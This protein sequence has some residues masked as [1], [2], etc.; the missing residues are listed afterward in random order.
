MAITEITA[1]AVRAAGIA[2]PVLTQV[3]DLFRPDE[4]IQVEWTAPDYTR[5]T[6]C[7]GLYTYERGQKQTFIIKGKPGFCAAVL[8]D[9][10]QNGRVLQQL[11]VAQ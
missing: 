10:R 5:V 6:I 9:L 4:T 2:V 1:Q 3:K 7:W 11:T 8:A